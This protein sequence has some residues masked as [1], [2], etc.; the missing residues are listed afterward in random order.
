MGK[1]GRAVAQD[2]QFKWLRLCAIALAC[3]IASAAFA[4]DTAT[5]E[6]KRVN[7]DSQFR[8]AFSFGLS[9][10]MVVS[11]SV[12][13]MLTLGTQDRENPFP[14]APALRV[15]GELGL[16]GGSAAAGLYIPVGDIFEVSLKAER[17]RTWLLTW[18]EPTGRIFNGGVVEVALPSLHGG[19]KVGLG[20]FREASPVNGTRRSFTYVF[21][22]LGW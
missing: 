2:K 20:S 14:T 12:G 1:T 15:D 22:G 18:G 17:M 16:G 8:P 11:A 19:P 21:V 13:A 5:L 3:A 9:Y 4:E 6:G 7:W 10:P